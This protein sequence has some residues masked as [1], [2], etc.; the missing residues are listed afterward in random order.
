MAHA[1]NN[2]ATAWSLVL[3]RYDNKRLQFMYHMNGLYDLPQLTK[4]Q[5]AD[6]KHML[7]VATVC[8]N[9][10]KN[11]D[12]QHWMAHHLTSRLPSPTLQ[13][14]ELHL[15]SS[16]ELATF[17]QLQS[18]LNDR[19]VSIDVFENRG[20]S[21]TRTPV[22][23]SVGN[24][25]YKGNSFHAKTAVAEHTRCPH[26]IDSHNLRHCPD[27]L[28]KDC[29]ARKAIVDHAKACLNCLSRSHALSKCTSKRNCTQ[30]GQRHHTLL[31]FPTPAQVA[32]QPHAA[33][34]SARFGNSWQYST[35]DSSGRAT[36][37]QLYARTPLATQST[38]QPLPG[39]PNTSS[40]GHPQSAA[41]N[42]SVRTH[43]AQLVSATA[44]HHGPSTVLLATALVTIHNPHIGQSAVV[45]ALVD[46]GSEGTLITEHTVQALNLKRHPISAEIAGVGTTSKNRCTYT[47]ELS[48]SSCTSQ[49]CTTIDTAFI[50][51]TLTSQLP[52]KSIK[53]QQC[54]HLN[55][56]EL[57]DPGFYKPQ[58]IDLLLGADVIPQILLS[59]I[60]RGKENQPIAQHTQ[61]GWIVFGRATS[62]RSHAVTIRCHHN[63]LE[64]LVQKFFEM[65]HLGSAKQLTPEERWCEEHFKRTH[66]RQR[67]GKYLVRLPLKRLF[68][69]SQVLGKSR[70]I[71]MNRFQ[72]LQRRF[73]RQPELQAKYSEVMNEYFQ[74]GQVTKVT[75]KEQQH[76]IISK[77]NGIESTCCTLP[78]HAV[79]KEES[80]TTK[81]RVVYDASCKTSN[82]KSLND[83]LCTRPALQNDLAGVVL[84]WRF[85]R[86][87][88]AA[89]I[90]KMYRCIDMNAEDSQCQRIFWHDEH[91]QV[92]EY[93]LNTVTFG[94]AS[95][96]YTA[97]RVIRQLAQ[98]ERD[99]YP[100]AERVLRHEIY[101]DDVQSGASTREGALEIQNQLIGALRSAGMELRKWS[102]NDASL[103]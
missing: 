53:L 43:S 42:S 80:V 62:T 94:T 12:V 56:I 15:G 16:A 40:S 54:P 44:T 19:L 101:V 86:F 60:R 57:T 95:A 73:Q 3:K 11:L 18:F 96:P 33:S 10:F 28:S 70:Q 98:D 4:E 66:I 58:R 9:A 6:I 97:I 82:G 71:A 50:L 59:D 65:E 8:L 49:F 52:S 2:Y 34:H 32:T 81:V 100:L 90:Q 72:M 41:T 84:N 61:L 79:F 48:L 25:T 31:H 64:N 45:R 46:S 51:K 69:P 103:L 7:N 93:Y 92:A 68:D 14:W 77:E 102:A 27:L 26:C 36:P 75:T 87:V 17:S 85:H 55:G 21:T 63:R 83:V 29:F 39:V 47:T 13:A 5:S 99:R 91:N 37:T 74:L 35:S 24:V 22:P 89:D 76:C 38:A 30:C 20:H 67:N 88:F 23:V 1:G 78:H